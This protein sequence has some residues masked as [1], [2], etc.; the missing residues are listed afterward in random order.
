VY[1]RQVFINFLSNALKFTHQGEVVIRANSVSSAEGNVTLKFEISDTGVGISDTQKERL[2][3][4]FSQADTS[5]ARRYGGTGLGL[6]ICHKL[7]QL[8]GG[9]T[10]VDSELGVGSTF[11]FTIEAE[12]WPTET[13][14]A[15]LLDPETTNDRKILVVDSNEKHAQ[16]LHRL[17]LSW[18]LNISTETSLDTNL[19]PYDLIIVNRSSTIEKG[20]LLRC[21]S[22]P[23]T[24]LILLSNLAE[25]KD[26]TLNS[27][28]NISSLIKP[29]SQTRLAAAIANSSKMEEATPVYSS[30][31]KLKRSNPGKMKFRALAVDDNETNLFCA[32][33][34]LKR[35][36][37]ATDLAA[38]GKE[39]I[40]MC[41]ENEYDMIF[42]DLSMPDMNGFETTEN[43]FQLYPD[44][45]TPPIIALTAN[46]MPED[47]TACQNVG[48]AGFI[49]KPVKLEEL[50]KAIESL[51][52]AYESSRLGD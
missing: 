44:G 48:M 49:T 14:L 39:A 34:L 30:K 47:R 26:G 38:S 10:W 1:K 2:F 31:T 29:Y 21:A 17:L 4:A 37:I 51:I 6:A 11:Y 9:R 43:I 16:A 18:N 33:E 28:L 25:S 36:G 40:A 24:S 45:N 5:I 3:E 19:S 27:R 32:Q 41:S 22:R 52:P 12:L 42:M 50:H 7:A 23:G 8:M 13:Y 15:P 35:I 46:A 20:E